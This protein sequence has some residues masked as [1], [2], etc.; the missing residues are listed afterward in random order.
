METLK[1]I[2]HKKLGVD[3]NFESILVFIQ[4]NDAS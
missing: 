1:V 4:I 3:Q 2:I